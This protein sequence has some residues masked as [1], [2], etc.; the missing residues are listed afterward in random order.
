MEDIHRLLK[1]APGLEE[2]A[3]ACV[4]SPYRCE[5][6]RH[7]P[8]LS[9]Y[10][11]LRKI[12]MTEDDFISGAETKRPTNSAPVSLLPHCIQSIVVTYAVLRSSEVLH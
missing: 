11:Q 3:I 8:N 10:L 9:M 1:T 7:C 6:E 5:G 12:E 2:L 4:T